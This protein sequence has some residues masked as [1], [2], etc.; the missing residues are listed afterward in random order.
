MLIC[1]GLCPVATCFALQQ[2]LSVMAGCL[3]NNMLH[4][5]WECTSVGA[6]CIGN[7][8]HPSPTELHHSGFSCARSETL[9]LEHL[10]S[11]F[12][13]SHCA[14]PN[15]VSLESPGLAHCPRLVQSDGYANLPSQVSDCQLNRAIKILLEMQHP[16]TL[17]ALTGSCNPELVLQCHHKLLT[18]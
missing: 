1:R 15:A 6:D 12:F 13:L 2:S 9:Q 17:C 14:G 10:E 16:L 7:G 5:Q 18:L 11:P 3:G 4:Q 8:G